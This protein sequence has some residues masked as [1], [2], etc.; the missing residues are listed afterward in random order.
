MEDD[1]DPANVTSAFGR[2]GIRRLPL[3]P[4]SPPRSRGRRVPS[5]YFASGI[6]MIFT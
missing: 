2:F 5:A 6:S 4:R 3:P 1:E